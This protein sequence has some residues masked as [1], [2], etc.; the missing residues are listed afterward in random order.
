MGPNLII[1]FDPGVTTGMAWWRRTQ[2]F[3]SKENIEQVPNC[4]TDDGI[5]KLLWHI[6][7][8][9]LLSGDVLFVV[10]GFEFR[11]DDSQTRDKID[12]TAAEVIGVLRT[13]ALDRARTTLIKQGAAKGKGFWTDEKLKKMGLWVPGNKHAMDALRHVLTYRLFTLN[14]K[15]LLEPF[16]PEKS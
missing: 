4:N 6:T 8:K 12:Y 1:G 5:R 14:H 7:N 9:S 10:E 2:A 15:E 13:V 3:Q 11:Q 16:R